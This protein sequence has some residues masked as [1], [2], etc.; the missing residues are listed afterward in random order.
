MKE[1]K[2]MKVEITQDVMKLLKNY[3]YELK[4]NRGNCAEK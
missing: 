4:K 1:I 3:R 2:D